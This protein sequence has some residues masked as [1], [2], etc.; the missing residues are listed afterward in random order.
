MHCVLE[1]YANSGERNSF[2][3]L[4]I[5]MLWIRKI[6]T[7]RFYSDTIIINGGKCDKQWTEKGN[8]GRTKRRINNWI[9]EKW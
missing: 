9:A 3:A 7:V 2:F 4:I 5:C 8:K 6:R 1:E